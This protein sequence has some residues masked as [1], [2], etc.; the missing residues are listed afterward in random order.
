MAFT[1]VALSPFVM[2]CL[3]VTYYSV[4]NWSATCLSTQLIYIIYIYIW[5]VTIF[6]FDKLSFQYQP[7][8]KRGIPHWP[9]QTQ[10]AQFMIK[11]PRVTGGIIFW[12]VSSATAISTTTILFNFPG[13]P[14]KPISSNHTGLTSG[15]GKIFWHPSQWPLVKVTKLLK[16]DRI[17]LVLKIKWEPLIQSLQ[18]LVGIFPLSCFPHDQILEEFCWK[19]FSAIFCKI[20]NP[21]FPSWTF[22]L[23]Y[24]RNAWSNWYEPKR[25]WI[26]WMLCW[27]GYLWLWPLT[28]TFD[29]EF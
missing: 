17:Y 14:L 16:W 20:S 18:N 4:G 8:F 25:K 6:L 28:W 26:N 15:V 27:L 2:T 24:L 5:W 3:S 10:S 19:L 9:S 13:K 21:F 1:S 23:P 29:L 22:Y 7:M 11:S 12:S